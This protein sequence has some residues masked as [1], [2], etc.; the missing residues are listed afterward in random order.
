M[1]IVRAAA[2]HE[3]QERASGAPA[4]LVRRHRRLLH[5]R[6]SPSGRVRGRLEPLQ[7]RLGRAA[8]VHLLGARH[9][10]PI[11]RFV[12]VAGPAAC[13]RCEAGVA[14]C[15]H[16]PSRTSRA[17][18]GALVLLQ[19]GIFPCADPLWLHSKALGSTMNGQ[20][21]VLFLASPSSKHFGWPLHPRASRS[22]RQSTLEASGRWMRAVTTTTSPLDAFHLRLDAEQIDARDV[23]NTGVDCRAP[24]HVIDRRRNG[25]DALLLVP[26][27]AATQPTRV[28]LGSQGSNDPRA[29][30]QA[31][32]VPWRHGGRRGDAHQTTIDGPG[33]RTAASRCWPRSETGGAAKT[34]LESFAAVGSFLRER[35][36]TSHR[37][38]WPSS[39][40]PLSA[41]DW[42]LP[43]VAAW[44]SPHEI[45]AWALP[46]TK[47]RR[48]DE[49]AR[50]SA[51][52]HQIA[53]P[54]TGR[55]DALLT[56]ELIRARTRRSL[57]ARQALSNRPPCAS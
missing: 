45:P 13:V 1:V 41:R 16:S 27:E 7:L 55:A 2:A 51:S 35:G 53:R 11:Q 40:R 5:V 9:N 19:V 18:H 12:F 25:R 47:R 46:G 8:S 49:W 23:T 52:V 50:A 48:R 32:R 36:R 29:V 37:A 14:G 21:V 17:P 4:A 39:A 57:H 20:R 31:A 54:R 42:L 24:R 30:S 44:R 28:V 56:P 10:R 15:V 38:P 33:A 43:S 26:H 6:Q 34:Q 3:A 22:N